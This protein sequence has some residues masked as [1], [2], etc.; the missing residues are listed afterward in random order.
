MKYEIDVS[1]EIMDKI[2]KKNIDSLYEHQYCQ[3]VYAIKNAK[4]I[5][6]KGEN[7]DKKQEAID[8]ICEMATD[9]QIAFESKQGVALLM[10]IE[11]LK[12]K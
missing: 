5:E 2:K 4:P 1:E 9:L 3:F 7:S 12:G 6:L 11:A 10:A 8:V